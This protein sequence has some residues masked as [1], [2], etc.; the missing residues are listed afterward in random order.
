MSNS[1]GY[2]F[3]IR[4]EAQGWSWVAIDSRGAIRARGTAPSRAVAAAYVI[5]TIARD[6]SVQGGGR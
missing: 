4:P 5:R 6:V 2:S 1:V 3:S